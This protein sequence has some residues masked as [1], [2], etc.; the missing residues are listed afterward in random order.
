M[1]V[2]KWKVIMIMV[3]HHKQDS[4][5]ELGGND[6]QHEVCHALCGAAANDADECTGA[7]EDQ[8]HGDDVL[9][10]DAL[11]HDLKLLVEA[12]TAVL[13][14]GHQDGHQEGDDDGDVVEAHG[15]L[16]AVFKQQAEAQIDHQEYAD[17]KQRNGISFFHK[18]SPPY[19][20]DV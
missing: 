14:A 8:Q 9:V 2:F 4:H 3:G 1:K 7:Q 10:T 12:Q 19:F 18:F 13:Q 20:R 15:D 6:V 11:T 17:G 5:G 16:H